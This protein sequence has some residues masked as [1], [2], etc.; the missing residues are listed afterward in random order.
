MLGKE[1]VGEV[2]NYPSRFQDSSDSLIVKK[3]MFYND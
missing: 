1:N 2:I 3:N